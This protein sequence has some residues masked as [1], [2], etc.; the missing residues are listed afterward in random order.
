MKNVLKERDAGVITVVD[1]MFKDTT[2]KDSDFVQCEV[3]SIKWTWTGR[4]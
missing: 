2:G 4:Y 3:P 1:G